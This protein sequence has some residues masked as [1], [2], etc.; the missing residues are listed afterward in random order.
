[1]DKYGPGY[2][3]ALLHDIC[4][5]LYAN[6]EEFLYYQTHR[7]DPRLMPTLA[8]HLG[9]W[10]EVQP[11]GRPIRG[12]HQFVRNMGGRVVCIDYGHWEGRE[13][14]LQNS[15]ADQGMLS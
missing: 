4:F 14:P 9:G 7:D 13:V 15:E 11:K 10:V 5:G 2:F 1:M 3:R 8:L 6:R 12:E